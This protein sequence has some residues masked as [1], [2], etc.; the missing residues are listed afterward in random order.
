MVFQLNGGVSDAEQR[1]IDKENHEREMR[2]LEALKE[3][4]INEFLNNLQNGAINISTTD[5]CPIILKK[6]EEPSIIMNNISLHE[7]RA[8]RQTIGGY[9][10]TSVRVAKGVSFRVGGMK[11][12]SESHEELRNIDQG[13]LVLTNKRLIFIG[14]KRTTNIDL[15]KIVAIEPYRDGISSQRENKQK[16]EYFIGT[17]RSTVSFTK[18][19]RSTTIPITGVVLKAAIQGNIAKLG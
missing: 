2:E 13:S 18:D 6:N 11:A 5:Y 14:S 7:P 8:V 17:D 3:R 19:G 4:D 16:T 9:R 12:R 10:G 1:R 15:R